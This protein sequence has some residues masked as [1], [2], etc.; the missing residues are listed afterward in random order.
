MSSR[1]RRDWQLF[2]ALL[3][4]IDVAAIVLA[5]GVSGLALR[6]GEHRGTLEASDGSGRWLLG[7]TIVFLLLVF[8]WQGLY[9]LDNLLGGAQ[10][11]VRVLHSCT[12]GVLALATLSYFAGGNPLVS[13]AWLVLTWFFTILCVGFTRFLVRRVLTRLYHRGV[14]LRRLL[15]A[16]ANDHGAVIGTYLHASSGTVVVGFVDDFLSTGSVVVNARRNGSVDSLRVLGDPATIQTLI[17]EHRVDEVII[18]PQSLSWESL[19]LLLAEATRAPHGSAVRYRIAPGL[20]DVLAG[21]LRPLPQGHIPLFALDATQL[22]GI[23]AALKWLFDRAGAALFLALSA[24]A[25]AGAM[26]WGQLARHRPLFERRRIADHNGQPFELTLFGPWLEDR[27]L[28]RGLPALWLVFRGRMSLV[29]PRPKSPEAWAAIGAYASYA[30]LAKPGLTGP[31]RLAGETVSVERQLALDLWYLRNY[32]IWEDLRIL[33]QTAQG[34][35]ALG[36]RRR[37]ALTRWARTT[38]AEQPLSSS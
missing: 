21:G 5:N 26:A 25:I 7:A 18:V 15:I 8:A 23:D 37:P 22:T 12:Y 11:Y 19:A 4:G 33:F 28:L 29:G 27:L 1:H 2:R 34:L 10:E 31:W 14:L 17:A 9:Q 36:V 3:L 35:P 20:H 32:S 16:G 38:T 30:R 13:R 24:P 6:L